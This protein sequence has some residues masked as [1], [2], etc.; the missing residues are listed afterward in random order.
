MKF[1]FA[2]KLIAASAIFMLA[3]PAFSHILL[4][5]KTAPAGSSYK[6]VFQVGHGCQGSA[7]TGITVRI[8]A[9]FQG[10]KPYPKAGWT[11]VVKQEKLAKPYD[12]HGKP[13]TEDVSVVSWTAASKEAALQDAFSGD[14]ML[15]G[16]LPE[17]A[18]PL[19]FK[20][21]QT[22]ESGSLDW[23]DVPAAGA[24]SKGLKFPAL[25]LEVTGP[26]TA[27]AAADSAPAHAPGA[28]QH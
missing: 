11:L 10:A 16:K 3:V 20:V 14:F 21:L 17:T 1:L 26:E 5:T 27:A 18:G 12:S 13:V 25:L 8:P 9:G 19:W 2:T 15:R 22:C 6:A 7:T 23:S 24:S 28:H 4:E